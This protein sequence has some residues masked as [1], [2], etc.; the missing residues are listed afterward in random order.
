MSENLTFTCIGRGHGAPAMPATRQ[1]W[2]ALRREPWL[3]Q[4]C[5]RIEAGEEKLKHQLPIWTPH[6][7][8]FK[9]N[10]RANADALR[11]LPRL[12]LDFDQ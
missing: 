1:E 4:M 3:A 7:A 11:P 5:S 6:C 12:M 2:E 9:N 8:E 10:H